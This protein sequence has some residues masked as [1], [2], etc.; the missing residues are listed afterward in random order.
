MA[1][2]QPNVSDGRQDC[3][4]ENVFDNDDSGAFDRP[5]DHR[6]KLQIFYGRFT[7]TACASLAFQYQ[8]IEG[9]RHQ[10]TQ[11]HSAGARGSRHQ[12]IRDCRVSQAQIIAMTLR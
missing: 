8:L 5:L 11:S 7:F 12:I 4:F 9:T 1:R 6:W 10:F 3:Q 2:R